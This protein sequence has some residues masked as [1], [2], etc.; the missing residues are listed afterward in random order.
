M[1][2]GECISLYQVTSCPYEQR[3]VVAVGDLGM[4]GPDTVIELSS[5]I[6]TAEVCLLCSSG[7]HWGQFCPWRGMYVW[8]HLVVTTESQWV[9]GGF[10]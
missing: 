2:K 7:S 4:C 1:V 9:R 10:Y 8:G 6:S 3:W 5:K